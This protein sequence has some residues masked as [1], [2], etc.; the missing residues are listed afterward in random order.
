MSQNVSKWAQNRP[1]L[2]ICAPQMVE[3]RCWNNTLL[4]QF[5]SPTTTHNFKLLRDF[6]WA[7]TRH[8]GL[9]TAQ[10]HLVGH[11]KWSRNQ[12][13]QN[14]VFGPRTLGDTP[15]APTVRGPGTL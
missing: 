15:L 8:Q 13:A 14:V 11:P 12:F 2:L 10:K 3:H 1:I 7:K 6:A 4:I 5:S 9:K